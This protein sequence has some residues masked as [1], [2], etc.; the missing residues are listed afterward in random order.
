MP[1]D[2]L[3]SGVIRA[4]DILISSDPNDR[5]IATLKTTKLTLQNDIQQ[6]QRIEY[7]QYPTGIITP[8][9]SNIQQSGIITPQQNEIRDIY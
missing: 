9:Q 7:A 6:D 3:K 5:S 2:Q 1:K 4:I 8:Q